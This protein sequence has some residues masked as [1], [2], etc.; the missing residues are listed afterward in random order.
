MRQLIVVI[1]LSIALLYECTPA[2]ANSAAAGEIVYRHLSDS[3]YQVIFKLYTDCSGNA[4]PATVMVCIGD[5]CGNNSFSRTV[6]R[7]TGL[8]RNNTMPNGAETPIACKPKEQTKCTDINST[9]PGYREWWYVDTITLPSRCTG[10]RLSATVNARNSNNNLH[11]GN[12][13]VETWFNNQL[14]FNNSSPDFAN[15]SLM[16]VCLNQPFTYNIGATDADGDSLNIEVVP[17]KVAPM[18][19]C[20]VSPDTLGIIATNPPY[21]WNNNP[22]QTN[23]SFTL[24]N[25]TG[26][27]KYTATGSNIRTNTLTVR[28]NEYRNGQLIGSV[29]RDMQLYIF[30]CG[31]GASPGGG[32]SWLPNYEFKKYI[33]PGGESLG[34]VWAKTGQPIHLVYTATSDDKESLIILANNHDT[35]FSNSTFYYIG[36]KSNNV[37]GHFFWTPGKDDTGY[38]N[39]VTLITDSA[40][41]PPGIFPTFMHTTSIVVSLG[42]E[43]ITADGNIKVYP[44]PN[45]GLFSLSLPVRNRNWHVEVTNIYG[46]KVYADDNYTTGQ[47]IDLTILPAGTYITSAVQDHVVYRGVVIVK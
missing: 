7:H 14:S 37:E 11:N 2:K 42:T 1:I 29:Y 16:F 4:G 41:R 38:Y 45:N 3:S 18:F 8:I 22:F 34:R 27:M 28:I 24:N 10:W 33:V 26:E 39:L 47:S 9:L 15:Q 43:E 23:N 30:S 13:Y 46:Q 32:S 21:N 6:P 31:G 44:N 40:C 20:P 35:T 17:V 5:T 25:S 12:F 19:A 36:N